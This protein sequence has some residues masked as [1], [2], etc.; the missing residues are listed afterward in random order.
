MVL[1]YID[2]N[3]RQVYMAPHPEPAS[4]LP[5]L[6]LPL[7]HPNSLALS[8]LYHA[9]NL[10]WRF[11]SH[12]IIYMFKCHSPKSSHPHP[13]Q[14][15]SKRLCPFCCLSYRVIITIFL[16][17]YICIQFSSVAQLCPTLCNPMNRSMPGLPVHQQLPEFTQT[18]VH[19][20]SDAIQ[21]SHPL[22]S[23]SP[24]A[25]NLSQHQSLFQ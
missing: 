21:P 9:S 1:P 11:I 10:H 16:I 14:K 25:P 13:L 17:P 12:I 23:P 8:S 15:K 24:P 4:H 22:S 7:G 2:M 19:R 6:P 18:H 20:V 5:P 3:P